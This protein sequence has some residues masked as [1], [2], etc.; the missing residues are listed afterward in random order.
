M[1]YQISD[2]PHK[3]GCCT[4]EKYPLPSPPIYLSMSYRGANS[5][6]SFEMS[7]IK[8]NFLHY[9]TRP[10]GNILALLTTFPQGWN[11]HPPSHNHVGLHLHI[12]ARS[13]DS[14]IIIG[15]CHQT[16]PDG[17]QQLILNGHLSLLSDTR[18]Q[19]L[20]ANV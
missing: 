1:F 16:R 3:K 19:T 12:S 18:G 17:N 8:F 5:T 2:L 7:D 15:N 9:G 6:R 4:R 13:V 10:I 20:T 11:L 14:S